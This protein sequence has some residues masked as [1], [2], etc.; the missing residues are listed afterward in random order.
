MFS[1]W[2]I[3]PVVAL[4]FGAVCTLGL[5][6]IVLWALIEKRI[7]AKREYERNKGKS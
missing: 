6:I 2:H 4:L 7:I 1:G 3:V 5:I